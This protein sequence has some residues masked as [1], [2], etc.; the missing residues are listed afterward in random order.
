MSMV[1]FNNNYLREKK[2]RW[3]EGRL[4]NVVEDKADQTSAE[5]VP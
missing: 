4:E 5:L 1:K 2:N 3:D